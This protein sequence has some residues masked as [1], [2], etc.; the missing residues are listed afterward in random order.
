MTM[1][2]SERLRSILNTPGIHPVP[3]CYDALSTLL[4]RRA[5]FPVAFISGYGVAASRFGLP[6][7]GLISGSE[8][9]DTL[10]A[11][12]SGIPDYPFLADGDQGYGNA[13][14]V[15][16]TVVDFARAGAAGI[17]I[18]D[19]ITPKRCGHLSGKEVVT[20]KEAKLRIRAAIEARTESGMDIVIMARSDALAVN[21]FD[22]AL[23]RLLDAQEE[24]AD[25]LFMEAM[26]TETQMEAFIKAVHKPACANNFPGGR[27][28][29]LQR[30]RLEQIGFKLVIDPTLLFSA[31]FTLQQHLRAFAN[32]VETAYPP[33][34]PFQDMNELLGMGIHAKIEERYKS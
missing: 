6:D 7:V 12:A 14:N 16:K 2:T 4:A 20:R 31:T 32:N 18:E 8:M 28:P 27:T 1:K 10:R 21:G 15:R 30:R 13:M 34:V 26:T 22:D 17:M 9:T 33:R 29:Y 11:I 5:G 19:Q 25:I 23:S 3:G 24:G